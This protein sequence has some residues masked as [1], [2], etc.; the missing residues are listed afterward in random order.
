M[1]REGSAISLCLSADNNG[2]ANIWSHEYSERIER[3]EM[4]EQLRDITRR[5]D[6]E[7][8]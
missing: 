8:T 5:G 2:Y 7:V 6:N 1:F 3:Y 4:L